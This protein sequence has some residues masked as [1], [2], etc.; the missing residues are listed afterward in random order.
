MLIVLTVWDRGRIQVAWDIRKRQE[1]TILFILTE[2]VFA[3]VHELLCAVEP[4]AGAPP[5]VR[6]LLAAGAEHLERGVVDELCLLH[7]LHTKIFKVTDKNIL[8]I[9]FL[10]TAL[11][12]GN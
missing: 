6:L 7:H 10:C 12:T 11:L 8:H 3:D 4:R 5:H 2:L 1:D 9:W